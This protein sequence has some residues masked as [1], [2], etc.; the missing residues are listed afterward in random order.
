MQE[1]KR[2]EKSTKANC[3]S[4]DGWGRPSGT[5]KAN[6]SDP[7]RPK[8]RVGCLHSC[9]RV[10]ESSSRSP[11]QAAELPLREGTQGGAC[12]AGPAPCTGLWTGGAGWGSP[13]GTPKL[14]C[15]PAPGASPVLPLTSCSP[16]WLWRSRGSTDSTQQP[17]VAGLNPET[18]PGIS[19][20]S[21]SSSRPPFLSPSFS[22][23]KVCR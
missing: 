22:T 14:C 1:R 6:S 20:A 15:G 8:C 7:Q 12:A 5:E 16:L 18:I 19:F 4:Q 23:Q 10:P 13:P 11:S 2:G 3:T 17:R 9:T 21:F